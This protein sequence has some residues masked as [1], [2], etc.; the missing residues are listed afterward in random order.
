MPDHIRKKIVALKAAEPYTGVNFAHFT[1][2]LQE[3]GVSYIRNILVNVGIKSPKHHSPT[4]KMLLIHHGPDRKPSGNRSRRTPALMIGWEPA[5]TTPSTATSMT[6]SAVSR[7]LLA[8]YECLLGYLE[9]TRQTIENFGIPSELYP[10]KV[11]VFFVNSKKNSDLTLAGQLEGLS[12]KDTTR[13]SAYER[14]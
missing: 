6:R 2:I 13:T 11:G 10:D 5:R 14:T 12:V 1:E 4:R 9:V 3:Q 8:K 7:P